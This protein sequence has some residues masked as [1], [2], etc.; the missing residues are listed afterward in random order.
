MIKIDTIKIYSIILKRVLKITSQR[1]SRFKMQSV[2][3]PITQIKSNSLFIRQIKWYKPI[4]I[5][6]SFIVTDV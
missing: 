1:D 5:Q 4:S 6:N 3:P 2:K